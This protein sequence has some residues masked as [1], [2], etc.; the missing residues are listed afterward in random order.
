MQL[1]FHRTLAV[2]ASIL[3]AACGALAQESVTLPRKEYEELQRRAATADR[4]RIELETAQTE[5]TRL[6]QVTSGHSPKVVAA[7][8]SKP[9]TKAPAPA[10]AA[11]PPPA[12]APA[13][14]VASTLVATPLAPLRD[15]EVADVTDVIRDYALG[16]AAAV[17]RYEKKP[18]R[19]Q[20]VIAAFA[21]PSF[22][23]D[24]EIVFRTAEGQL[25]CRASP[26]MEYTAVF[27]TKSG[28]VLS[29]RTERGSQK[30][31]LK[32]GDVVT[33]EATGQGLKDGQV[34]FSRGQVLDSR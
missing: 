15:G 24:Y 19:L 28:A 21:K 17:A 5:L 29:G 27:T 1:T 23:R 2:L 8:I 13:R 34:L 6:K 22:R 10:V 12:T 20:G 9:E 3:L 30:D 14:P 26:P 16:P 18:V 31:L 33:L 32:V 11:T 4:L 7:P 25:V